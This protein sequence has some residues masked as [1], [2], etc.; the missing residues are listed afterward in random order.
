[1]RTTL[2]AKELQAAVKAIGQAIGSRS[3]MPILGGVRMYGNGAGLELDATDLE[4]WGRVYVGNPVDHDAG[5]DVALVNGATFIRVAHALPKGSS[6]VLELSGTP[7]APVVGFNGAT[8]PTLPLLDFPE[9]I[10]TAGAVPLA[11]LTGEEFKT[12]AKFA[13]TC[14]LKAGETTR[15]SLQ[16]TFLSWT[17]GGRSIEAGAPL[18][19]VATNGYRLSLQH[20]GSILPG[21]DEPGEI[22]VDAAALAGVASLVGKGET[23]SLAVKHTGREYFAPVNGE[24]GEQVKH[25]EPDCPLLV[26]SFGRCEFTL[27]TIAEEFP[28]FERVIPRDHPVSVVVDRVA[29]LETLAQVAPFLPDD[30]EAC[31]IRIPALGDVLLEVST[32]SKDRGD[33]SKLL[34]GNISGDLASPDAI[35]AK[36]GTLIERGV[37]FR[38][39]YLVDALKALETARVQIHFGKV[40]Q[41]CTI[42][43]LAGPN[44]IWHAD[45]LAKLYVCMPCLVNW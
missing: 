32:S 17:Q 38:L 27:R 37:S 45:K 18:R 4:T 9:R 6:A 5:P 8:L 44:E 2:E 23:V 25:V 14:A 41:A 34:P 28:D 22:L 19:M 11:T 26:V 36:H 30:S 42:E 20:V 13:K 33:V 1:M 40:S 43:P 15:L 35:D 3:S 21:N 29:M 31:R 12:A 10:D 24:D 39:P 16:G 7:T